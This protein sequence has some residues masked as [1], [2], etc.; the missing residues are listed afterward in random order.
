MK[1]RAMTHRVFLQI[2]GM[3]PP[4]V[5][6]GGLSADYARVLQIVF[7]CLVPEKGQGDGKDRLFEG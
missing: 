7:D 6:L 1:S 2:F 3:V 5:M 4:V